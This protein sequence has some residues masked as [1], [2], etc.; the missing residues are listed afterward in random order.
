MITT[1]RKMCGGH[2][3]YKDG[4]LVGEIWKFTKASKKNKFGLSI[5]GAF[6]KLP[7]VYWR[8]GKPTNWGAMGIG[9][10]RLQD[11]VT[12]A[13]EYFKENP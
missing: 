11:C 1:K 7:T 5:G 10:P 13:E 4:E 8:D 12:I 2:W 3:L 6:T 9:A